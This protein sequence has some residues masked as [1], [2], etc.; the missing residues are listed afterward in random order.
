MASAMTSAIQ[1]AELLRAV[2]RISIRSGKAS[3]FLCVS[4]RRFTGEEDS[5]LFATNNRVISD[6]S[7]RSLKTYIFEFPSLANLKQFQFTE[8]NIESAWTDEKVDATL[9]EIKK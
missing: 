6:I 5:Y 7:I 2:C 3:G 4:K 8:E 9:I 1:I